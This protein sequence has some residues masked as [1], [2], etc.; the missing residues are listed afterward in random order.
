MA[1]MQEQNGTVCDKTVTHAQNG[2]KATISNMTHFAMTLDRSHSWSGIPA[3]P[4]PE[5][6]PPNSKVILT[7]LNENYFGSKGVVVYT[8][9]NAVGMDCS[10]VLAWHALA[11]NKSPPNRVHVLCGPKKFIDRLSFDEIQEA[12]D[13]LDN[14]LPSNT[15]TDQATKTYAD[16]NID[17][18]VPTFATLI[19]DFKLVR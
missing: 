5:T 4:F 2:I 16:G 1:T 13:D 18:L 7:H 14:A 19:A 15:F 12:I 10:W 3:N 11:D 6:I 17:D 9:R 8:G